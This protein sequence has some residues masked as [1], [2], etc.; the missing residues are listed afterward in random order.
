MYCYLHDFFKRAAKSKHC[1]TITLV[2]S[3]SIKL[4]IKCKN[5]KKKGRR[6]RWKK[7]NEEIPWSWHWNTKHFISITQ[8]ILNKY[9]QIFQPPLRYNG[10]QWSQVLAILFKNWR[11]QSMKLKMQHSVKVKKK[12]K[13]VGKKKEKCKKMLKKKK[14]N[15]CH[16]HQTGCCKSKRETITVKSV[17][18]IF[19]ILFSCQ[20][21][22]TIYRLCSVF[23]P[24]D[25]APV[26]FL[27]TGKYCIQ[28]M[29]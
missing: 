9:L 3:S 16:A 23:Q 11:R 7:E 28:V 24:F 10:I 6:G 22:A 27:T 21:W 19:Y 29:C 20:I 1:Y 17:A 14:Q 25:H 4:N 18:A 26:S 15:I 8:I 13:K 5:R 2:W 12:E